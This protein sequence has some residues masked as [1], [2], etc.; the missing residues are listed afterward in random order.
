[1]K[2]T[3]S[4]GCGLRNISVLI[5]GQLITSRVETIESYLKD[6]VEILAVI[7]L[8]GAFAAE[9]V[10]RLTLYHPGRPMRQVSLPS[11]RIRKMTWYKQ[12]LLLLVF[13]TWAWNI[14]SSLLR[15]W[16]R[17]DLFI[18]VSIFSTCMGLILRHLGLVHRVIY[19]CLDYYPP[20]SGWDLVGRLLTFRRLDRWCACSA[21]IVWNL[22]SCIAEARYRFGGL[23]PTEY[24][25]VVVPLGYPARLLRSYPFEEIERWTIVFVGTL[26]WTQGLQLLVDAMPDIV[27][28]LPEIR[29]RIIGTGPYAKELRQ[30]VHRTGLENRFVFHG[31][32]RDDEEV[33]N[34]VARCAVGIAPWI[35]TA[36]DNSI[37]ADPGKPKLYAFCG[38]PIVITNGPAVSQ[39]IHARGAGL[40]IPYERQALV[41][42][43]ITILK[44]DNDLKRYRANATSFARHYTAEHLFDQAFRD[45][46]ALLA[47]DVVPPSKSTGLMPPGG[48]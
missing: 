38:V 37:F 39:E 47:T 15:L 31:F 41:D 5:A 25:Q 21:D 19:Y 29:V 44:C 24:R 35:S 4:I 32:V 48:S 30:L 13:A 45:S 16:R 26:V 18:G 36:E 42:A 40:A 11:V 27:A 12:P 33:C 46:L 34:I 9:N 28:Q 8:T 17:F 2:S 22:S 14:A 23:K 7:G 20:P 6:R 10:G 43:L 3:A 1:M